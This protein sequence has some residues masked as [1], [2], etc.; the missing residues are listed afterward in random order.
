MLKNSIALIGLL[1][2]YLFQPLLARPYVAGRP[3]RSE[4]Q[5]V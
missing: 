3:P 2:V 4:N 5:A 1:I